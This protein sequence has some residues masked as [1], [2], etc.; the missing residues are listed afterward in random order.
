MAASNHPAGL[1][2]R[3][4]VPAVCVFLA[5][6]VWF[7]FGQTLHHAF[8][9]YDDQDYVYENPIVQKG[10]TWDGFRWAFTHVAASNWHP[11]TWI[12]HMLDC[13]LY[14]LNPAGHHLTNVVLHWL[15]AT[16]LFLVL[17][18]MLCLRGEVAATQ[19]GALWR[20]A[21]VAA[22]FALHPLRVESVA[23]VA[24]RKDVLS[25]VFF[26]L[27]L[28]AYAEYS[29]RGRRSVGSGEGGAKGKHPTPV[30][31]HP[32]FIG[33]QGS[34]SALRP[35]FP[36]PSS[37]F[38]LLSLLCFALGLMCKPMLVTLPLVLL[39]LD[40]W[41]LGRF[42]FPTLATPLSPLSSPLLWRM[43]L[44]KVPFLALA[45]ASCV[46]TV[47]AQQQALQSLESTTLPQRLS[48]AALA[49]VAYLGQLFWPARL[50]VLYPLPAGDVNLLTTVLSLALLAGVS[51]WVLVH[52]RRQP[53]L[54]TGWVWYLIMLLPVIGLIQVGSQ[55]RADRYTYLP[56]IGLYLLLTWAAADWC[57]GWRHRR[58]LLG[59]GAAA[60]LAA[61]MVGARAQAAHW[62]NAETLWTHTLACTRD[63][64]LAHINLGDDLLNHGR[65]DEAM[66]QFQAALQIH[67]NSAQAH[68]N[69]GSILA[70]K[71]EA[72]EAVA[73]FQT[74][75]RIQPENCLAHA[76]LARVLFYQLGRADEAMAQ[77][78][79]ALEIRPGLAPAHL[80]LGDIL[81]QKGQDAGALAQ[82]QQAQ[83]AEPD[84]PP[85]LN[86]LSWI[87]ATS[88]DA[89]LRNGEQAVQYAK[90]ACD[91]TK[92]NV[93]AFVNGE[94]AAYAEAGRYDEAVAAAQLACAL[95]SKGGQLDVLEE[96]RKE[97]E[98]YRARQ[99][100]HRTHAGT[101]PAVQR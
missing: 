78:Q 25:G 49:Y 9:N 13:E 54:L 31:Q 85:I 63:N 91:L 81:L 44:E 8:V 15:A 92:D 20:S 74:A 23:W 48:N 39:L 6:I 51:T 42:S 93:A 1:P 18:R 68:N 101:S 67:P 52:R 22:V 87:L 66:V 64:W 14:G 59:V 80:I 76:N 33:G 69:L 94:A 7:V 90:R 71:D 43:L 50:A 47:F 10:L 11:L 88:P 3:F 58:A 16:L 38:Y 95:A 32:T 27:T 98:L 61:F 28:W 37:L 97:L 72:N 2:N 45:A 56:Q 53:Y 83:Q 40:Y 62:R 79:R 73:H 34:T 77:C 70:Q 36:L 46:V 89:N 4:A 30:I 29:E 84:S 5:A 41:P 24:E 12:S 57:A 21:F 35:L 100:Y 19:T 75:L 86:D 17:R 96:T 60:I 26:M 99:P 55:A 82:Y 65:A